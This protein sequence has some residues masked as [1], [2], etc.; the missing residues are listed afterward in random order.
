M[1]PT[2]R[3]S[4]VLSNLPF[5]LESENLYFTALIIMI[6]NK[7]NYEAIDVYYIFRIVIATL[8]VY[9]NFISVLSYLGIYDIRSEAFLMFTSL[10]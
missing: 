8:F 5:Y 10:I 6:K 9:F 1:D 7:R 4:L 3:L 2:Y